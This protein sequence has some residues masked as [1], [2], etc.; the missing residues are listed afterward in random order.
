MFDIAISICKE[1]LDFLLKKQQINRENKDRLSNLFN[2]ISIILEDT[3]KKL[4]NNDYPHGNCRLLE[5]LSIKLIDYLQNSITDEE[6]IKLSNILKEI[7]QVE[8]LYAIKD[9]PKTIPMIESASGEFKLM[10]ILLKI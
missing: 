5:G 8:M 9:D 2:E 3:A 7:S 4:K 6:L 10:S 1:A